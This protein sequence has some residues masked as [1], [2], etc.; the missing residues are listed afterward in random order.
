VTGTMPQP[1]QTA[2]PTM[3]SELLPPSAQRGQSMVEYAIICT[4]LTLALFVPIPGSQSQMT[5]AQ[6]LAH[7]LRQFYSALSY[8]LSLP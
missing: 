5:A 1:K 2:E 8:F 6:M 7:A 4:V 3:K